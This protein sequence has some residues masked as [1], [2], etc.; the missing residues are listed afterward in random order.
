MK[1][2]KKGNSDLEAVYML[3]AWEIEEATE[4][5]ETIEYWDVLQIEKD[6][7]AMEDAV[8]EDKFISKNYQKCFERVHAISKKRLDTNSD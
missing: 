6:E 3:E 8:L 4:A 7:E 1:G 2:N 5:L